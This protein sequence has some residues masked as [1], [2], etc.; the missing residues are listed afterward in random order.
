MAARYWVG[1]SATWD[2]TA[3]SKWSLTS[4]GAGGQAVPTAS[5]DVFFDAAS[6][7]VTVTVATG[8]TCLNADFTGFTGTLAGSG[9]WS[10]TGSLTLATGMTRTY[11]GA[12]TFN[13][14]A[15][16]RTITMNGKTLASSMAFTGAGGVWQF[17]DA[18]TTTGAMTHTAGT[19]DMNG[20]AVSVLSFATTGATARTLTL[21][22]TTLTCTSTTVPFTY[23]GSNL[24]LNEGTSTIICSGGGTFAGNGETYYIL[25]MTANTALAISSG[26]YTQTAHHAITGAN[27]FHTISRT[28]TGGNTALFL[29]ADQTVSTQLTITGNN[30]NTERIFV[31]S[32]VL[33]TT[34]TITCNGSFSLTNVDFE[35]I[36]AAGSAGTWSG[37]SLGD[38]EGCSNITFTG[39]V[40]RYWV[41]SATASL[42][43]D[44]AGRWSTSSGGAVGASNPLP[45]DTA[46]FDA[47][48]IPTTGRTVTLTAGF[49]YPKI[50]AS[51][52]TNTPTFGGTVAVILYDDVIWGSNMQLQNSASFSK[53][54]RGRGSQVLTS[55]GMTS[56]RHSQ[57]PYFIQSIGGTYTLGDAMT[58]TGA[59]TL[60]NGTFDMGGFNYTTTGVFTTSGT[61]ARTLVIGSGT[62]TCGTWT[63]TTIT[64]FTF[65]SYAGLLN[66][67]GSTTFNGG[68]DT[69]GGVVQL[70]GQTVTLAGAN[71]ITTLNWQG[72]FINAL[73]ISAANT[74][75]DLNLFPASSGQL[76][77]IV[78]L[79]ANQTVSGVL[80]L[81]A[82][83]SF[84]ERAFLTSSVRGTARTVTVNGSYGTISNFDFEDITIAGSAGTLSG[85]SLGNAWGNTNITFATPRTLYWIDLSPGNPIEFYGD[86][87][88]AATSGGT[89]GQPDPLPQDTAIFDAA[90]F[91]ASG[92]IGINTGPNRLPNMDF[93]A[94]DQNVQFSG[95]VSP[96]YYGNLIGSATLNLALTGS[97]IFRGRS[98]HTITHPGGSLTGGTVT[99]D[100]F[101]GTHT[102]GSDVGSS[103]APLTL[104]SGTLELSSYK[105]TC[106]HYTSTGSV[107]RELNMGSG[108][109]EVWGNWTTS[110][111]TSYTQ[112]HGTSTVIFT[113]TNTTTQQIFITN[114]TINFYNFRIEGSG[115]RAIDLRSSTSN[116][117]M[118]ING[119]LVNTG[120]A[121]TV[122]GN[123]SF[124]QITVI[125]SMDG[126]TGTSG[127]VLT[128][129]DPL[130]AGVNFIKAS[131]TVSVDY[132]DINGSS[133]GGGATFYAGANS[134]DGGS[135][136]GWIFTAPPGGATPSGMF[137]FF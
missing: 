37:T 126:F 8:R 81:W 9:T 133:A 26:L 134:T 17:Q 112:T 87:A 97:A 71:T 29:A 63:N 57:G 46:I 20:F 80:T 2:G 74:F 98:T 137:S 135:N 48:S 1:G 24:T 62:L 125:G 91:N 6:G 129:N 111:A 4:G 67:T 82:G 123:N 61:L 120:A 130:S 116:F 31:A 103:Q 104:T 10:I 51:A 132:M 44:T 75:T 15:A 38:C 127:N 115:V 47:S 56:S 41:H 96:A 66:Q 68:G 36:T 100:S 30:I 21:G 106:F 70:S 128:L 94:I 69:Y 39:A 52:I 84:L 108:T 105:F 93:S 124:V 77:S 118:T 16:G 49:R 14:T 122:Q 64:N 58:H 117:S 73:T 110:P 95:G 45:Q 54:L 114:A 109:L 7:A 34:R 86:G 88:W 65:G 113:N 102:L 43:W 32:T 42:N 85:T 11:T 121:H 18:L 131:G 33:G 23:T 27:T 89:P 40:T 22:A 72:T 50:D 101:T 35:D 78:T 12:L 99:I 79:A 13:S 90:S 28:N 5:D 76:S 3:G 83:G 25:S 119:D 53:S 55:N 107:T 59:F 92:F 136:S 19:I 60:S